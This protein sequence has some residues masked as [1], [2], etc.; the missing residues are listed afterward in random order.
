MSNRCWYFD[1]SCHTFM[2]VPVKVL[3][4]F[5]WMFLRFVGLD[6]S[7]QTPLTM[8]QYR[9]WF[10]KYSHV[11]KITMRKNDKNDWPSPSATE[12]FDGAERIHQFESLQSCAPSSTPSFRLS[13]DFCLIWIRPTSC[14]LNFVQCKIEGAIHFWKKSQKFPKLSRKFVWNLLVWVILQ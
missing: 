8:L 2:A 4:I 3:D 13:M 5:D 14:L 1:S 6:F 10:Q 11:L 7:F 12:R 9:S